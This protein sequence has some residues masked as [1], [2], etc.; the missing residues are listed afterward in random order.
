MT[1]TTVADYTGRHCSFLGE[2][3]IIVAFLVAAGRVEDILILQISAFEELLPKWVLE[4]PSQ[5]IFFIM[6]VI[7][8]C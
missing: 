5:R 7:F 6:L 1:L 3:L 2:Q 4:L 8:G